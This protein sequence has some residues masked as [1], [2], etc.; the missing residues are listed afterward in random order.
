[1]SIH[2]SRQHP[3]ILDG[4]KVSWPP[5]SSLSVNKMLTKRCPS[6]VLIALAVFTTA[7]SHE[8]L[9]QEIS[10]IARVAGSALPLPGTSILLVDK[11]GTIVR[12]TLTTADGHFVLTVPSTGQFRVKARRM[13]FAPDSSAELHIGPSSELRFDPA[14]KPVMVRLQSVTVQ[15][16]QRCE[17]NPTSDL[18][19][20][21]LWNAAQN[22]LT[23]T[24]A[25]IGSGRH[26]YRLQRFVQEVEPASSQVIQGS[27]LH[28]RAA[29][30][31]PYYSLSPDSLAK[32]GFASVERDSSVYFAP[33]ARTL[34]SE[35]FARTHC[36]R[37]VRDS[38]RP[39]ELGLAFRPVSPINLVDVSGVLW[40][41]R[42]SGE[43]R[44][45][46][47]HYE[48][49]AS[50][51]GRV[52][53]RGIRLANGQIDYRRLGNGIWI[54]DRWVIRVPIQSEMRT[55]TFRLDAG[56]ARRDTQL[57]N[58]ATADPTWEI[59]GRVSAVL[60]SNDT[61]LAEEERIAALK[62][63]VLTGSNGFGVPQL[64]VTIRSLSAT[65]IEAAKKTDT[66][67]VFSFTELPPDDYELRINSPK[68]DT[69]RIS[70]API[71]VTLAAGTEVTLPIKI[72]S[73]REARAALCRDQ[74]SRMPVAL[75]GSV[76][77]SVTGQAIANA[78]LEAFWLSPSGGSKPPVARKSVV[79]TDK[80]GH[81]VFCE[82]E[83]T[84]SLTLVISLT[85]SRK[86]ERHWV[87]PI[88]LTD[89]DIHMANIRIARQ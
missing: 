26:A 15:A 4:C 72:P 50:S 2:G 59:G 78:R 14:L 17:I 5:L 61:S 31:E 89:S 83:P 84:S 36:L 43:L 23:A 7:V 44:A 76:I 6:T 25:A 1:M 58:A 70:I 69:L 37:A 51:R 63:R 54:V 60:D 85:S 88:A 80:S 86:F 10:G 12:G 16:T 49:P 38:A 21:D 40:I 73:R 27:L 22:A 62:G 41:H 77:D 48:A 75:H 45:L 11:S 18:A 79:S 55:R 3:D 24:I 47:Y 9:S 71:R 29:T 19:V 28:F 39:E 42:A 33:D 13:G 67:G 66:A 8:V 57:A 46:E 74:G 30:T 64:D 68:L 65:V 87:A 82:L 35:A 20:F 52:L 81:F 32:V 56:S 34:T 53:P